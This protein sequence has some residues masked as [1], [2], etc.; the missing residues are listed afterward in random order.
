MP[1]ARPA[2]VDVMPGLALPIVGVLARDDSTHA[3]ARERVAA[4]LG[5]VV[6]EGGPWPFEATDYYAAESGTPLARRFLALGERVSP[7]RLADLKLATGAIEAEAA[8]VLGPAVGVARPLNL[9]PGLL[10]PRRLVLA[11]TKDRSQ[12]IW[13]RDGIYA[14]VTL[15]YRSGGWE[16]LPW[17]FPDFRAGRYDEFLDRCRRRVLDADQA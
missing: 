7:G 10:D 8:R 2:H 17:T 12:R 1:R 14:E 3:W 5:A 13:L 16:A 11:S 15:L 4:A 9:D 6:D